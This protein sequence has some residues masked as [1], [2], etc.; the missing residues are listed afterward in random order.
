MY[1]R[2]SQGTQKK[3]YNI[4]LDV[5]LRSKIYNLQFFCFGEAVGLKRLD[6]LRD[7]FRSLRR[8]RLILRREVLDCLKKTP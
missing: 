6:Q 8:G 3:A 1:V 5:V 4:K 2:K 7:G